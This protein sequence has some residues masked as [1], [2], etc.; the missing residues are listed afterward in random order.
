MKGLSQIQVLQFSFGTLLGLCLL[1]HALSSCDLLHVIEHHR[2]ASIAAL[3]CFALTALLYIRSRPRGVFMVDYSCFKPDFDQKASYEVCEYFVRRSQRFST[4]SEEFMR[5]IYLK[6]GL[7]DETYVPPFI[8][9]H[10]YE[11]KLSSAIEE[12]EQGMFGAITDLLAKTNV[13]VSEIDHLIVTSGVFA[14]TPSLSS[15]IVNRFGMKESV[16]TFNLNGMGCSSG[17]ASIDLAGRI[18]RNRRKGSYALVVVTESIS[19]NWY[20]GDNRSMLVTNCIFRLGTAAVLLTNRK[21]ESVK[22]ELIDSLRTHHGADDR[23][24]RAAIQEEDEHG[25]VGFSLTKDLIRVAGEGLRAHLRV[26][27]PRVLPYSQLLAYVYA[28]AKSKLLVSGSAAKPYVPDFTSAFEHICIHTGG[29]AVI[30]NIARVLKLN[31]DV[32]EPSRM[33]LHRF[34]NTSS[35]LVF[36]EYAYFEAKKRVKKG[37]KVWMLAFGTGF[38]VCSLVWKAMHDSSLDQSNP[39][40]DCIHRY[41][42]KAW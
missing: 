30:E 29:K 17:V 3:W 6:S 26:F 37:D 40:S 27:A 5:G 34:G 11:A 7:G 22:L 13:P 14:V 12:A 4:V 8:F 25:T 41:P 38:K 36:Y 1:L 2:N 9:N 42:V 18:L 39:W 10:D 23:A 20:F 32:T 33:T 28:A 15:R 19:Q 35:S 21:S 31:D 24:Y 16:R